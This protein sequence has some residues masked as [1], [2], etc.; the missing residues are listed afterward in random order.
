MV[1]TDL[2]QFIAL[3]RDVFGLYPTA[4]PL[5]DGQVAMFFRALAPH[6]LSAVR[7]GLDAHVR[8]PQRGRF[9]PLPADVLAQ[10]E[11]AAKVDGRPGPEEAWA[12]AAAAADESATV[13]WTQEIAQAWA[14]SRPVADAGDDVGARMAFKEAYTRMVA[15]AR[16]AGEAV[17]WQ[18]SLGHDPE[19][20]ALSIEQAVAARRLPASAALEFQARGPVALLEGPA[21]AL[22]ESKQAQAI[23]ALVALRQRL[24]PAVGMP[25]AADAERAR[26]AGLKAQAQ[27]R[28]DAATGGADAA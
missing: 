28:V 21:N 5:T 8:D 3:L 9:P 11:D 16:A 1:E 17:R 22:P 25:T 4:K 26:M 12:I 20:R 27:A 6:P 18:P 10:I 19:L 7:S 14:V 15:A 2:D 23:Q 13:V 24:A